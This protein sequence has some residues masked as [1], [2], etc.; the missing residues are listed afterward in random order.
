MHLIIRTQYDGEE[1]RSVEGIYRIDDSG[2]DEEF[3]VATAA[4]EDLTTCADQ[5][6]DGWSWILSQVEIRLKAAGITYDSLEFSSDE[7]AL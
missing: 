5:G 6:K 1:Y 2:F 7:P 3:E 4:C